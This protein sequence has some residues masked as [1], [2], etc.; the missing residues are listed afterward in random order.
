MLPAT[1]VEMQAQRENH[2]ALHGGRIIGEDLSPT[3][4]CVVNTSFTLQW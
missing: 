1:I 2:M 4:T 3:T